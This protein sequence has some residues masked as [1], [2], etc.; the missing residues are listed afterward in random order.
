VEIM[1]TTHL[2]QQGEHMPRIAA[3]YGFGDYETI[4]NHPD[5]AAL[6][7]LRENPNVL[8]P[9][10]TVIVPDKTPKDMTRPTGQ[11]HRF[12]VRAPAL[13]LR[14]RFLGFDSKPIVGATLDLVI[15]G[16][17]KSV[18]TNSEGKIEEPLA[19]KAEKGL[20]QF[21]DPK[22]PFDHTMQI[23]IRVGHL[24]PVE[25]E[26]GQRG[27]LNALGYEAGDPTQSGDDDPAFRSAVEEFQCDNGLTV[28]GIVGPKT[29]AKLKD[30]YGC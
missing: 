20:I 22:T 9:G 16:N 17:S 21:Q 18:A 30:V 23:E 2:V 5:N 12:V 15:D 8:L 1:T 7:K 19:P 25:A 24:D 26:S 28:D 29:R 13:R 6:K 10:D 27:R 11:V 14:V 4:W 3:Q